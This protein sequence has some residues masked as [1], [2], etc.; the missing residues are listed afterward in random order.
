MQILISPE[1]S[2]FP[3]LRHLEDDSAVS[4]L[5]RL[6]EYFLNFQLKFL[7]NLY[8][9]FE[10]FFLQKR[11]LSHRNVYEKI[12]CKQKIDIEVF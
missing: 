12:E 10:N 5:S 6:F 1:Y 2:L 9:S 3:S 7:P 8:I 11:A 4:D